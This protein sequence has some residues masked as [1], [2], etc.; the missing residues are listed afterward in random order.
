MRHLK[1]YASL[2]YAL[3]LAFLMV[4]RLAIAQSSVSLYGS[5]DVFLGTQSATVNGKRTSLTLLGDNAESVS[6][7]GVRGT[8]DIGGGN[9]VNF[10]LENGFDPTTGRQQNAFRFFDR[11]A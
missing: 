7:L 2:G 9:H 10:A 1:K 5:Y 8:E 3:L 11:Q 4:P 6:R